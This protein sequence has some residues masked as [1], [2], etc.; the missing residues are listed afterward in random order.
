MLCDGSKYLPGA[1][2]ASSM[3]WITEPALRTSFT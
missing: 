3:P 2:M 1:E